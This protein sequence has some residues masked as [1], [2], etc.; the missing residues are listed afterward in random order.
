MK[1]YLFIFLSL[2]CS[3]AYAMPPETIAQLSARITV[4]DGSGYYVL[5]DNSCWK[6]IYFSKRWRSLSEWWN[7]VRLVPEMFECSP[8]DWIEGI[9]LATV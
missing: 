8:K 6:V 1:K 3:M 4:A 7:N 9:A 5:S 2:L